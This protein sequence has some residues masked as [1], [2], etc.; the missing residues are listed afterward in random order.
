MHEEAVE[1]STDY[2]EAR[3]RFLDDV[4]TWARGVVIRLSDQPAN[5]SHDQGTI[6][7]AWLPYIRARRDAR[8]LEFMIARRDAIRD[9]FV[10]AG[11]WHHGYWRRQ[12]AHHG[13]EHFELFLGALLDLQ[14][15]DKETRH[16]LLDAAEH[17]GNW[18]EGIPAWFDWETGLF[19]SMWL[20]TE[21]VDRKPGAQ[22][23][24]PD[25]LRCVNICLIAHRAS[26]D[27]RYLRLAR[28][29]ATRWA[30]AITQDAPLPVGLDAQEAVRD[31]TDEANQLYHQFAGQAPESRHDVDRA[32][33]LLASGAVHTFVRLWEMTGDATLRRAAER[34]LDVLATQLQDPDAGSAADAL[35]F[36]RRATGDQRYDP[37]VLAAVAPLDPRP[38]SRLRIE[39]PPNRK[40]RPEGIGKRS[41]MPEWYENDNPRRHNPILLA[42]AAE[43]TDDRELATRSLDLGRAYLHVARNVYPDGEMHGCSARTVSAIARGHGRE[44]GAG[45]VTAVLGPL[46]DHIG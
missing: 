33:N 26:G 28:Q 11:K 22:L 19:H 2:Q 8:P 25:H 27:A 3:D 4:G 40:K 5:N 34:L 45:V 20:G 46:I 6:T 9:R 24:V 44:N 10:M 14:P 36:Y 12:E 23:N 41:D 35:R 32:E 16:Q 15:Q 38:I 39:Q 21:V 29:H 13:T 37:L 30:D 7:T 42:F 1:R 31:L 18:V 17:I 43:I